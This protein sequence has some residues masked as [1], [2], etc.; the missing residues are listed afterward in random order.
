MLVSLL[1]KKNLEFVRIGPSHP[2]Y[3]IKATAIDDPNLTMIH[4]DIMQEND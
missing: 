4:H 2:S 3:W 1:L